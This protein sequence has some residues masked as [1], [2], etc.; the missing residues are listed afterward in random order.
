MLELVYSR[1]SAE[2]L[3]QEMGWSFEMAELMLNEHARRDELPVDV[4][5]FQ[6]DPDRKVVPPCPGGLGSRL[7]GSG[8]G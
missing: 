1:S 6:T 4:I 8:T 5:P 2:I 3:A 7:S